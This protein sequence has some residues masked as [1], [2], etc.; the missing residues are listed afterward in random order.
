MKGIE[1]C[2]TIE[3]QTTERL[4]SAPEKEET[5]MQAFR[6]R[7]LTVAALAVLGLALFLSAAAPLPQPQPTPAAV[8]EIVLTLDPAQSTVHW[9]LDSSLHTVHGTFALKSGTLH[10]DT[11]T[12]K[13]GG[14][15]VVFA[16]S[17]KSGNSSR[18]ERMH[19]EILET[20]RYPEVIFHPTQVEG[21]VGQAGASDVKLN[22]VFSIHGAD[23]DLTALVH[24]ELT[25]DRWKGTGTFEVPYVKWGIKN[26]SNFLLK[27]KPVVRVELEM[28]G[29][30][31]TAN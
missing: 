13:A 14:E 18:D 3:R 10:F 12:G 23:H 15:I 8:S 30:V 16:T 28:S 4:A 19:K 7:S 20:S 31:K 11:E 25:G 26:P 22:G 27:V 9:T 29:E 6:A 17:G 1:V 24:A 5:N 2:T 21:A